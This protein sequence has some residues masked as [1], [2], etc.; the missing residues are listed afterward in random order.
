MNTTYHTTANQPCHGSN[1]LGVP[2]FEAFDRGSVCLLFWRKQEGQ[3][4][5]S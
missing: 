4:H 3:N 5:G 1:N 2:T